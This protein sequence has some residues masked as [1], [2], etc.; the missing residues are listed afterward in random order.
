[1]STDLHLIFPVSVRRGRRV[2]GV[3]DR[4]V[5]DIARLSFRALHEIFKHLTPAPRG[6]MATDFFEDC[7]VFYMAPSPGNELP[8]LG[9]EVHDES[10]V[11]LH[12][13]APG[14]NVEV[15]PSRITGRYSPAATRSK[16]SVRT[17]QA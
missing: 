2:L 10:T 5:P 15:C 7:A 9:K 4:C 1:M 16:H 17:V 13:H 11:A 8:P 3:P 14:C 12:K 6:A